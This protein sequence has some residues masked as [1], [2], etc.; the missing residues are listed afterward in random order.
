[1]FIHVLTLKDTRLWACRVAKKGGK[2]ILRVKALV[3][4]AMLSSFPF[5]LHV[6]IHRFE[7]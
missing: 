6:F 4:R 3:I 1:M 2:E 7:E 5:V